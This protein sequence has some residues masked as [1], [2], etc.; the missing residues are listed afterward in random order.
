MILCILLG[1]LFLAL[2]I[3]LFMGKGAWLIA[4]YNT[5]P[6]EEKQK[7]N[8]K[9]LCKTTGLIC[10]VVAILLGVLSIFIYLA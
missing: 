1:L 6:E 9:K 4:G 2:S 3:F 5:L 10:L 8:E 7:Y